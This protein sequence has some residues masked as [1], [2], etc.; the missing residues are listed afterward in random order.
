MKPAVFPSLYLLDTGHKPV[1]AFPDTGISHLSLKLPYRTLLPRGRLQTSLAFSLPLLQLPPL[2]SW[3]NYCLPT[4]FFSQTLIVKLSSSS[5]LS[6]ILNY[7]ISNTKNPEWESQFP[8][9][10][11]LPYVGLLK[12]QSSWY[13]VE[14]T[15]KKLL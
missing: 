8:K 15:K 10:S 2:G 11:M 1:H 12:A 6:L 9:L 7:F 5:L 13:N 4:L 3:E 14:T